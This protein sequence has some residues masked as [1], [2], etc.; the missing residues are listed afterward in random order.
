MDEE[1][2]TMTSL[3]PAPFAATVA[4]SPW[5]QSRLSVP[6]QSKEGMRLKLSP[7]IDTQSGIFGISDMQFSTRENCQPR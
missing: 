7:S 4:G 6:I 2:N 3:D 1:W 5:V